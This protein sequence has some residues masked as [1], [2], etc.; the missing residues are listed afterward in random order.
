MK[1]DGGDLF[2]TL[3]HFLSPSLRDLYHL[4]SIANI[5]T[6]NHC[7]T[8]CLSHFGSLWVSIPELRTLQRISSHRFELK[9][10]QF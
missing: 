8:F 3:S 5:L 1:R 9:F 4:L 2:F 10:A 7:K 6:T